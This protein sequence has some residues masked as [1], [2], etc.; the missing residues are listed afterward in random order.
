MWQSRQP[1]FP[2]R[3]RSILRRNYILDAVIAC[4]VTID[5]DPCSN[6]WEIPN[7]P[8]ARY[9]TTQDNG[10]VQLGVGRVVLNP[11]FRKGRF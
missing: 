7:V 11:Q 10:L 9:S 1:C 8:A 2:T 3:A 6:S 5:P 4:M